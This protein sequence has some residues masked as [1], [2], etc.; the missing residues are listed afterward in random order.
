M[1]TCCC[2]NGID[3]SKVLKDTRRRT[4]E[5]GWRVGAA[6]W[7]EIERERE[8]EKCL[9]GG[10]VVGGGHLHSIPLRSLETK[11]SDINRGDSWWCLSVVLCVL[12]RIQATLQQWN[13][14]VIV[15]LTD[16]R[17]GNRLAVYVDIEMYPT[18]SRTWFNLT[19]FYVLFE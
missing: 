14:W 7:S 3:R 16:K 18:L 10:S 4:L 11:L 15:V 6:V 13:W 8:R 17:L 5:R 1:R 19:N 2:S 9:V 12:E